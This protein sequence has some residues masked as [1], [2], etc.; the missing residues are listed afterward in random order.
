MLFV[1]AFGKHGAYMDSLE[2]SPPLLALTIQQGL[3]VGSG[4]PWHEPSRDPWHPVLHV[5]LASKPTIWWL[6][7]W[8]KWVVLSSW[9]S[10]YFV[11]RVTVYWMLDYLGRWNTSLNVIRKTRP[12]DWSPEIVF[13]EDSTRELHQVPERDKQNYL[14]E[15][16]YRSKLTLYTPDEC[17][18][19]ITLRPGSWNPSMTGITRLVYMAATGLLSSVFDMSDR[20]LAQ[21]QCLITHSV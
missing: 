12:N 5:N 11:V 19:T 9:W 7:S 14:T 3:F 18:Q 1:L 16:R 20:S 8:F 15:R 21:N 17:S 6:P 13:A 10:L 2:Y 4:D